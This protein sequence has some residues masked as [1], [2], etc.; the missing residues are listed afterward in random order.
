MERNKERSLKQ[1]ASICTHDYSLCCAEETQTTLQ[2][3][4]APIKVLKKANSA[5]HVT[6]CDPSISRKLLT[7]SWA[8]TKCLS[9]LRNLNDRWL[10]RR[11]KK[12][13]F[14]K[15]KAIYYKCRINMWIRPALEEKLV[16]KK[17]LVT[18]PSFIQHFIGSVPCG[19]HPVGT[20]T[21]GKALPSKNWSTDVPD[22]QTWRSSPNTG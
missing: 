1:R 13:S 14:K 22:D 18:S 19:G 6:I 4:S 11:R 21:Q 12:L 16:K 8:K 5:E 7:G 2:S 10:S 15:K 3:N 17:Y 9:G 20:H